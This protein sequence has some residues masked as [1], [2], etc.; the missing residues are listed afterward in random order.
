[1]ALGLRPRRCSGG[2]AGAAWPTPTPRASSSEASTEAEHGDSTG[3]QTSEGQDKDTARKSTSSTTCLE[4]WGWQPKGPALRVA[5]WPRWHFACSKESPAAHDPTAF[6]EDGN[7]DAQE[8]T[9]FFLRPGKADLK[10]LSSC[11]LVPSHR[12][13]ALPVNKHSLKRPYSAAT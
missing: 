13:W 5:L 4:S 12:G 2:T 1:M 10:W 9:Q 3:H 11:N 6:T 7:R 8:L